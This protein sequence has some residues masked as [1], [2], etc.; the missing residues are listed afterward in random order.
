MGKLS[1]RGARFG[2][3][4]GALLSC[5]DNMTLPKTEDQIYGGLRN[6]ATRR[7]FEAGAAA[8]IEVLGASS[9]S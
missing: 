5:S 1:T 3:E 4:M 8:V 6:S 2:L 9:G 7:V